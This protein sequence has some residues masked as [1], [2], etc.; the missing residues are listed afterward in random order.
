MFIFAYRSADYKRPR[1]SV[2]VCVPQ[3]QEIVLH[4]SQVPS[5]HDME[6][7]KQDLPGQ[8]STSSIVDKVGC[9]QRE[10]QK[11][12]FDGCAFLVLWSLCFENLLIVFLVFRSFLDGDRA[13]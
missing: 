12:A 5:R 13:S 1:N 2:D 10:V 9:L 7:R 6:N 11:I 4:Q 3:E 8:A